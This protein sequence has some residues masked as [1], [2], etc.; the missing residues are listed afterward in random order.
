MS[1]YI[2]IGYTQKAHGVRGEIKLSVEQDYLEDLEYLDVLFISMNGNPIPYFLESLRFG[3]AIIAKFEDINDRNAANLI[4][5]KALM[6]KA[7]DLEGEVTETLE[8]AHFKGFTLVDELL[9]EIGI[10]KEVVEYPQ[11]EIATVV[12][13]G[14]E[15]LIPLNDDFISS[16]D[17]AKKIV[18]VSLPEGLVDLE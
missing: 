5:S 6:A 18:M 15:I 7:V 11:Q 14:N 10:I 1:E 12:Y 2:Q 9:G 17:E 3:N 16:F 4:A 8:Y 13:K